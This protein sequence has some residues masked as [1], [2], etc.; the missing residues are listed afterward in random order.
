MKMMLGLMT[1]VFLAAT[2]CASTGAMSATGAA[3]VTIT[4]EGG[5][6]TAANGATKHGEAC[7]QN[8]LGIAATGDSSI[9]A[10]KQRAGITQ[11]TNVD[12]DY[13]NILFL[14][15]QTCVHVYGN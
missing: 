10:A 4:K 1:L 7:S 11:V 12:R 6:A 3:L 15:G 13:L 8:I 9:E 5:E 14:Y 2:G